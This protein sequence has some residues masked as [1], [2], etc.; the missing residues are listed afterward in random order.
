MVNLSDPHASGDTWTTYT[1]VPYIATSENRG[2]LIETS[3]VSIFDFTNP[4]LID[5]E[6]LGARETRGRFFLG[7]DMFDLCEQYT[8]FSGRMNALPQWVFVR[9]GKSKNLRLRTVRL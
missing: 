3:H 7:K 9:A 8:A 6:I 2:L 5:V 1:S 4:S